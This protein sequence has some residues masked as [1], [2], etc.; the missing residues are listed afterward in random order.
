VVRSGIVIGRQGGVIE[1]MFWPF[2][3]GVGGPVASGQQYF[4]WIHI[5]DLISLI[6]Y[7]MENEKVSGVL[8]GVAPQ[9]IT[10]KEFAK[11]FGKAL[12]RPAFIPMPSFALN[13]AFSEERAKIMTE[14]QKVVPKRTLELGY[15]F[16]YS[17]IDSAVKTCTDVAVPSVKFQTNSK[18]RRG[19]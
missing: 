11:S 14:G 19:R 12:W 10:N 17:D 7:S 16:K 13:A 4:P 15:Q 8:N 5:H 9:V 3:F 18:G 1:Q 2:Y 6:L